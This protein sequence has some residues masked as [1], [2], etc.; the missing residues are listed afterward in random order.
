M[1][2]LATKESNTQQIKRASRPQKRSKKHPYIS[3]TQSHTHSNNGR[4]LV[5][6]DPLIHLDA[7]NL[8]DFQT[9]TASL[10]LSSKILLFVS[11]HKDHRLDI[12]KLTK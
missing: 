4:P 12:P 1:A 6:L 8:E 7:N 2:L 10:C 9:M 5:R 3:L 11:N